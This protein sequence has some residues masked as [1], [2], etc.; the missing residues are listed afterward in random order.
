MLG[1]AEKY[2][3]KDREL[4]KFYN[5]LQKILEK[6]WGYGIIKMQL[7]RQNLIVKL[8]AKGCGQNEIYYQW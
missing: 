4:Q 7:S 6:K 3:K 8:I 2:L 5:K 1:S